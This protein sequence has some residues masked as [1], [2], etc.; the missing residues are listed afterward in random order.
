MTFYHVVTQACLLHESLSAHITNL[1]FVTSVDH[2]VALQVSTP[3][4]HFTTKL[5]LELFDRIMSRQMILQ[6]C[7]IKEFLIA[8]RARDILL[9]HMDSPLVYIY[10]ITSVALIPADTASLYPNS[11][12]G[13]P[14]HPHFAIGDLARTF[15][16]IKERVYITF[17]SFELIFGLDFFIAYVT[18]EYV[19]YIQILS[20]FVRYLTVECHLVVSSNGSEACERLE[21]YYCI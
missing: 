21:L 6:R 13:C 12:L 11:V 10:Y 2:L 17:V 18:H 20:L 14:M 16:A 1:P 5:T 8:L 7:R 19:F 15:W 3:Q 4:K 9:F